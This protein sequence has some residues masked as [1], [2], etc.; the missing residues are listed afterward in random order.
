MP[1]KALAYA[2]LAEDT[3]KQLT[4]SHE[5]WTA[6]LTTAARVY[7]YPYTEQLMIFA[8][9]P[10]A[11]ACA[12]YGLWTNTMR[13]Y[14]R[15]GSKGIA[16]IDTTGAAPRIRYVFDVSDTGG[17]EDSRSPNLWTMEDRHV[18]E[19]AALLEREY[20]ANDPLL[21]QQ[22]D[23][24]ATRL[25]TQYWQENKRDILDIVDG[26]FLEGY[27]EYNV[28]AAFRQ[29]ASVSI[30]Y[31][32]MSRCG[33][34]PENQFGHEDF[35]SIFDF[36]TPQA[37]AAL[38][39]AV[40]Q[41]SQRVL[42]QIE[43][44]IRNAE[45][46]MEH[47]RNDE[48]P[49]LS[50]GRGRAAAQRD[51]GRDG[52][53]AHRE[54][55]EDAEEVSGTEPAR[56]VQFPGVQR[57]AAS[58]PAGDRGNGPEQAG[59]DDER[60][61]AE[62]G[63][64]R[65]AES[66]ESDGVGGADERPESTGGGNSFER[67]DLQLTEEQPE[68]PA[69]Q[70]EE[71]MTESAEEN[72]ASALSSSEP[73]EAV[74]NFPEMGT[75]QTSFFSGADSPAQPV[76]AAPLPHGLRYPQEIIDAALTIGANDLNSRKYITAYF[77][78]DKTDTENA[79]FLR[80]HY[81][82]NGAGFYVRDQQYAIWY[83]A[84]GIRLSAGTTARRD[85][86]Y[87]IPWEQAAQRIREL[88]DEGRYIPQSELQ[89]VSR[90]ELAELAES[91]LHLYGDLD[92]EYRGMRLLPTI[93]NVYNTRS[94]YPEM[95]AQVAELLKQPASL[96]NLEEE[97]QAFLNAYA[98]N[99]DILRFQYHRPRQYLTS[100][101]DLQRKPLTFT[102]A[103]DYDPQRRFFISD[104]EIDRLLQ[105]SV[106]DHDYRLG[107]YSFFL[108]NAESKA[109]EAYMK[110]V[111]GEHSGYYGGNDNIEYTRKGLSFSHGS[112]GA[113]YAA[114]KWT[115]N[116]AARRI[117]QLIQSGRFLADEDRAAMPEYERKQVAKQIVS[118]L[119]DAPEYIPRPFT[120]NAITDYW[121]N[122]QQTQEQLTDPERVQAIHASLLA[123]SE[124]TLPNDRR[125]T[126]RNQALDTVKDYMEEKYP[127]FGEKREPMLVSSDQTVKGEQEVSST[128]AKQENQEQSAITVE[129]PSS[130]SSA[131][132]EESRQETS[133][134]AVS[135]PA[136]SPR[137]IAQ[138]DIDEALREW[139][140]SMDSKRA[141][142]E[143]MRTHGRERDAAAWLRQE[144]G[145]DLPAYPV[146]GSVGAEGDISW[147]RVQRGILR[148]IQEDRFFT[149]EEKTENLSQE[150]NRE[151]YGETEEPEISA[152]SSAA[153]TPS[154][155][156]FIT[157]G[158]IHYRVGDTFQYTRPGG[159]A[160]S[161][162]LESIDENGDFVLSSD[163]FSDGERIA[164]LRSAIE[165][166]I[167]N[168]KYILKGGKEAEKAFHTPGGHTY[169]AGD[170]LDWVVDDDLHISIRID[171]VDAENVWCTFPGSED[172]ESTRMERKGFEAQIDSGSF[173]FAV[174]AQEQ[175][176]EEAPAPDID[177][178]ETVETIEQKDTAPLSAE[179]TVALPLSVEAA[180]EYNDLK[181]QHP[182]ALLG[183]EQHGY[184]EFY[185]DD[186]EK[187]ARILN[188]KTL[189]KEIPGGQVQ[190]TG[191]PADRWQSSFRKLW[192]TGSDVY[193]AGENQDGT[194]EETKYLRGQDYL[195]IHASVHIDHRKYEIVQVN[196]EQG[197]VTLRDIDSVPDARFPSIREE[198]T[199]FVRSYLEEEP[200]YPPM[201]EI[202]PDAAEREIENDTAAPQ[203]SEPS[204]PDSDIPK[205]GTEQD[206]NQSPPRMMET[207]VELTENGYQVTETRPV[208]EFQYD[209]MY[210]DIAY[211]DGQAY[212]VERIG[213]FDVQFQPLDTQNVYP[214]LRTE[215]MERL[216]TLLAQ[217]RRND[218]LL[219]TATL[220][221]RQQ[222]RETWQE[223]TQH[224]E[225]LQ[226]DD[227]SAP[228]QQTAPPPAA[229]NFRITDD[230][231]GEGGAKTKFKNNM[232]AIYTLKILENEGRPATP[233]EQETLSKYVGWG[234]LANAFDPEKREWS[235]EYKELQAALT[236]EEY[237]A[238]RA[239]TLNAHYTSPTVIRGIYE[240]LGNMGF[241]TGNILEPAMGVGNF[242]GMLPDEMRGSKLYGVELDS[243]TGRIAQKLYPQADITVAGFETT[244]R[245]DIFDVA[246][247]NVPFGN[248]KV[249]DRAYNK[250]GFNIHNYFFAKALDQV[251]P[252]GIV[253]FVTSRYTLDAKSPEVRKYLAQRAELLG[254]IRLP[255]N[256]F[257][258]NAGTEVTTDIIFLQKRDRPIDIEPDW[259]HLG[260]M[261]DGVPVNSYYVD[262]PEMVLGTMIWED[263][264]YGYE[265][266]TACQPVPGAD[267]GQQLSEAITHLQGTYQEAEL[268]DLAEGEEIEDSIPADPTVPNFSYTVVDGKVY[269]REDSRMVRPKL[270]QTA[271]ERTAG[272]VE[273]RNC[274]RQLMSAQLEN[275]SD[276]TIHALQERLNTLYDAYTAKY[277]LI[278]SRGNA[279]AFSDDSSYY[280][281]CS[282]EVLD[283]NGALERKADMFTK[284]TIRQQT[285][286]DHVDT[287][288][289]ALAL[290]I[291]ERAKVDLP[292][293]AH[294]TDKSEEEIINDLQGVIFRL[295]EPAGRD[296]RS[297]YVTA[298][299][300]LSGNVRQKLRF[301][302]SWADQDASFA[303]NVKALEAVQPQDLSASEINVRLGAT[304]IDKKYIQQFMYE[305]FNTPRRNRWSDYVYAAN[306]YAVTVNFS[307]MTA[308]WNIPNKRTI[309]SIDV[310]AYRTYGTDRASAYDLLEAALNLRDVKI[311]DKGY[312]ADGKET[313]VLNK[314]ETTL[315]Q[316]KM[317]AIKDAF[318]E[319]VW[320]DPE[321]RE[322][323]VREYN[324]R[325]NS[326]RPREFDGSHI[327]FAGMN[328]EIDLR[329]HQRNAIA[330][331]LYGG[332]TLLAHEVGAG[333]TFEMAAAAMESKRL[334]LCSKSMFVVPNH[335]T[336]QWASE[337]LRLYPSAKLLV[338]TKKDFEKK[339][340]KKFCARIATGDYD[341]VIIGHSQF[342]K[343]PISF[344]RQEQL[345]E[346]QIREIMD[347]IAE[348][349]ANNGERF[350]IKQMERSRKQLEARLEKLRAEHKKDD[351]VT[352]EELGVDRLYVDE[353]HFYK[354]LFCFTKM[355]NVA[356]LST[357]EA[358]KSSDMFMKCRYIDE[359]TGNRG[360]VFATGTPVS[361]SMVEMYTIQRYLQ[362]DTLK[363]K[364]MTHFDCW[365]STFGETVTALE[366]APEGTGYRARTRFAKFFNL[367]ELMNM[368]KE[369]A[370][371]KTA[372]QLNLPTPEA[373]YETIAVKP[374]EIQKQLVQALSERAAAVH[375]HMV[376]PSTDNMLK[377][378]SDGR[379][380][381]LDQRL[382]DPMLPD[383]PGSKVN[384]CVDNIFRIW[385]EGQ[386]DKLTQLVF[387]D[388]STPKSS[389]SSRSAPAPKEQEG[390]EEEKPEKTE[391]REETA[392]SDEGKADVE[393]TDAISS[394][395]PA[396]QNLDQF[397]VYDDIRAKLIAKGVPPEEIAFIHDANTEVRK[398]ELFAKVRSGQVRVLMGST[399]KMGAGTN[400]QDRLIALHDLDAPWR[401]GDLEQ[402]AG[403]IV[404][405][406]NKNKEVF[407]YRYV[408]EQSFDAYLWQ[409]LEN[410]QK[411]I[412]QIMTSKS[413]VRSCEDVDETALSYAE[414]KALCAGDPRIKQK[415]D[416]DIEVARLRLMKADHD[417][418]RYSLEDQIRKEFPKRISECQ[419]SIEGLQHDLERLAA[420]PLP[421][422]DFAGMTV[423]GKHYAEKKEAGA[424]IIEFCK[425]H[426]T[427]DR[428]EMG[429][430]RGFSMF[431][432]YDA[433]KK[434]FEVTLQ[435]DMS[436]WVA[437]GS[438]IHGN[439][440]RIDNALSG[441]TERLNGVKTS[442]ENY[443]SQLKAAQE[444]VLKPFPQEEELKEKSTRLAELNADL[445]MDGHR[446]QQQETEKTDTENEV[447][448]QARP[449]ILEQLQRPC[450]LR[451]GPAPN[452]QNYEVR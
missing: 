153:E 405:Q 164:V 68:E 151:A 252:G 80:D 14:V 138:A 350:N 83:D 122:V 321:R 253:A 351:V 397:S 352:F 162:L 257:T 301:A 226:P 319:W 29:A 191:F 412:S 77:M 331:I 50:A 428:V 246:V 276:N 5:R 99:R 312:D 20:G 233:E 342:E 265:K 127:L 146:H 296:G 27:D 285:V 71:P 221:Q 185:G 232:A 420:H 54:V 88:L 60:N 354:N 297:K 86:A 186:A 61:E 374:S 211:L 123:L 286:V 367:P 113:P 136:S 322:D 34:E 200:D 166:N 396:V 391:E 282:L 409:T 79:I 259:V 87:L 114:I 98:E 48:Q 447:A 318:R 332:N 395:E 291:A 108:A 76:D 435:G 334:G 130:P 290:S 372:D 384:V 110:S 22:F 33:M 52:N 437:L 132:R 387:C 423:D 195:P 338:T 118:A 187:A 295:P 204:I 357:A 346:E 197:T 25:A 167:D 12:E 267:L 399:A 31:M 298:D 373:H 203:E 316:Q 154:P 251:R 128:T 324:E 62:S 89:D 294:L 356:G 220:E 302:K 19:V 303:V 37:V 451:N 284:R 446:P 129:E 105:G 341:A 393:K 328:P 355:T 192:Q 36:N 314:K 260:E 264:M 75:E 217:D 38:G 243:I 445:N 377:I 245:R 206:N 148:L 168:G 274:V 201:E 306:R 225:A 401:P 142:M 424:A 198:N 400:C 143:Y 11:T 158:G 66:R 107:V 256:A 94:G 327:S 57:E 390:T 106:N 40:S 426:Y 157:P 84:S 249:N 3:A 111:H 104:D 237:T 152:P 323:L 160:A 218:H 172:A 381:G 380:L 103:P 81:K 344:A 270:S 415:M 58:A 421:E 407:I 309:P 411:F 125:Y 386:A 213:L 23:T 330:H 16:L 91:L 433:F 385:Q 42:R 112:I 439:I 345:L 406:G 441:I 288:V 35:M 307:P 329:P 100:I 293:M 339:N 47:E 335:L 239:S 26:S 149:E 438:D 8:Q 375:G 13:R 224:H 140:G 115:W 289:E 49:D 263:K 325:F 176:Q 193:L 410:K 347:G 212:Q 208:R 432:Q 1:D 244:D 199:E 117:G 304:W 163:R 369:V 165:E 116:Q 436:H 360:I 408:T 10:D 183:F 269:F 376:D 363:D 266:E 434:E 305:I 279:L 308:E 402:R 46:R 170:E 95:T 150:A 175:V 82:T 429:E 236:S 389:A 250:L 180:A 4:G 417:S 139:N 141:V 155:T 120:G 418:K 63:P 96:H 343:I 287:A 209:C 126:I 145:D 283:E 382:I 174:T 53:A 371:V 215:S 271:Q 32:L 398:K 315:A 416:L 366:L 72:E 161:I 85:S 56:V 281:L 452:K 134:Q 449:S 93:G 348:V 362:Y 189:I 97:M 101:A 431:L 425:K 135:S 216:E 337:F 67:A 121:E 333:K 15:R 205:A 177:S 262:H 272:M 311:Y 41:I 73:E 427:M 317:Q 39:N 255:S 442:L 202:Q 370:D 275:A 235:G 144:Y 238:A 443:E 124:M 336:E 300:Y 173:A 9:R 277:G 64:D 254:A 299:E 51:P 280:L 326:T 156:E 59:T 292:F 159:S 78:K 70:A 182:D 248:Y 190:V 430:Y 17:R 448:K 2:Q 414:I 278:N 178:S 210:H 359:L 222:A 353:S 273:L 413:P 131:A 240:A 7:K 196:Y 223:N 358:Q 179:E 43:V 137:T 65:E 28:G 184:Y 147:T 310:A 188:A 228:E 247:G 365:A 440:Q 444:E 169:R 45:R 313:R 378:T 207:V 349:K 171:R 18:D 230:H 181:A 364:S 231:L 361:N 21:V 74:F 229:E 24:V 69:R 450:P 340:R 419:H 261:P 227:V 320:K 6:F 109:R 241:K 90:L 392:L 92:S 403:R 194:H 55:R 368:F 219:R 404:R 379:K 242:F 383:H 214:V 44:T 133:S 119:E 30:T 102:A 258:A 394:P 388:L 234:G 268:P 422:K